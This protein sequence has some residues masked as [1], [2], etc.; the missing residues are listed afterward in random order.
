MDCYAMPGTVMGYF[1]LSST[2]FAMQ[3]PVL[4]Q[5]FRPVVLCNQYALSSTKARLLSYSCALRCPVLTSGIALPG[6]RGSRYAATAT[7]S[8]GRVRYLPT[9][10]PYAI[11]PTVLITL[12]C[13]YVYYITAH[14]TVPRSIASTPS[15]HFRPVPNQATVL[16]LDT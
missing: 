5:P 7:G 16:H 8:S 13:I 12:L 1:A 2:E 14:S 4:P 3:C 9:A 15:V 10:H 11:P 6:A